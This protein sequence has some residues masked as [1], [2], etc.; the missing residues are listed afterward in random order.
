[1]YDPGSHHGSPF[2]GFPSIPAVHT[3]VLVVI[4]RRWFTTLPQVPSSGRSRELALVPLSDSDS[5]AF[6]PDLQEQ[7]RSD[8]T[9]EV[10]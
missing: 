10:A 7:R 1:M 4:G 6:R 9:T 3:S 5:Q 8:P 2:E